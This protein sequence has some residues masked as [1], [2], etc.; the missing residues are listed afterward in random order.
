M[1]HRPE[2]APFLA[3]IRENPNDD[4]PRTVFADALDETGEPEAAAR[5]RFIRLQCE[6]AQGDDL[7]EQSFPNRALG[8]MERSKCPVPRCRCRPCMLR[9]RERELLDKFGQ[10]WREEALKPCVDAFNERVVEAAK[11]G[12]NLQTW[13][14]PSPWTWLFTERV[15]TF[16]RGFSSSLRMPLEPM[17]K[18]LSVLDAMWQCESVRAADREPFEGLADDEFKGKWWW[19]NE[20]S[21]GS[22]SCSLPVILWYRVASSQTRS[23]TFST[24]QLAHAA[25]STAILAHVRGL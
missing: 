9:R 13:P 6:I 3:A 25:L 19:V 4:L 2:F 14:E 7:C 12:V 10:T 8:E 17:L 1:I 16:R 15:V 22:I 24:N 18:W 21:G 20:P 11:N 23:R 5:A